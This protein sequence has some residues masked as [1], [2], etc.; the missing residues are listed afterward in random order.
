MFHKFIKDS[1]KILKPIK[2]TLPFS[3][4]QRNRG[5]SLDAG[6]R[7]KEEGKMTWA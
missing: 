5:T 4:Q 3:D 6:R 1:G 7:K 2:D